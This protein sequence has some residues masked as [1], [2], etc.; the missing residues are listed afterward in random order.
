MLLYMTCNVSV[1]LVLTETESKKVYVA[2]SG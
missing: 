1:V 2:D